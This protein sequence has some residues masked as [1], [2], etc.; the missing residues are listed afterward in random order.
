[1]EWVHYKTFTD[2]DVCKWLKLIEE[3][4]PRSV[5]YERWGVKQATVARR[6]KEYWKK[7]EDERG[8]ARNTAD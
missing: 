2:K 5:I 7:L 4:C 1:M 8:S 6:I 3:G